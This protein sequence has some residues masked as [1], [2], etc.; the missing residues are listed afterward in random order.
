MSFYKRHAPNH[1]EHKRELIL[2]DLEGMRAL[3]DEGTIPSRQWQE[4]VRRGKQLG[5]ECVDSVEDKSEISCFQRGELPQRYRE[6]Q[7]DPL[8]VFGLVVN[9]IILWNTRYSAAQ[10]IGLSARKHAGTLLVSFDLPE[11]LARGEMRP[12]R[13][14]NDPE[15]Q[16]IQVA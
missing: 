7:E 3:K 2:P 15:E 14:P 5:L 6:G 10:P 1:R 12:L 11:S 13:D 9:A 16:E 4:E 8:G